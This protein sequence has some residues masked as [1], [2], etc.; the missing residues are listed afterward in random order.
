MYILQ[1][2]ETSRILEVQ[3]KERKFFQKNVKIGIILHRTKIVFYIP[4]TLV[5]IKSI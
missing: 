4:L 1:N 3:V 5:L 2:S